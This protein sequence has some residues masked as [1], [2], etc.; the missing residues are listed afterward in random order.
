MGIL[1]TAWRS[2]IFNKFPP[3]FKTNDSYI[4]DDGEGL[5]ERYLSVPGEYMEEVEDFADNWV[6]N[7]KDLKTCYVQYISLHAN[8][9]GNPPD[10]FPYDINNENF[11]K[12]L[13]YV[14]SIYKIKGTLRSY[15]V[16][17]GLLGYRVEWVEEP[18]IPANWDESTLED[19]YNGLNPLQLELLG[20]NAKYQN[21][22]EF[23]WDMVCQKCV[24]YT[25]LISN[26]TDST[27]EFDFT[28]ISP[29][30]LTNLMQIVELVEPIDA[31]L[32]ALMQ[33]INIDE[34]VNID[35]D[36][37]I[38][39]T[40]FLFDSWD[41]INWDDFNWDNTTPSCD[42][43]ILSSLGDYNS[44]YNLDHNT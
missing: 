3:Y 2:F 1:G 43:T 9:L 22:D 35:L 13:T 18:F 25:L 27:T 24:Y 12:F 6:I 4:N 29:E 19:S 32:L 28:T 23:N 31:R 16:L 10:I 17:F 14:V 30:V 44:D 5:L 37:E 7:V 41:S 38:N 26:L 8:D 34:E 42:E 15:Q 40:C 39:I 33:A 20:I 11:R 21:W 36:E